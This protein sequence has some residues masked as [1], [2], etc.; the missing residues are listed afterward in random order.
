MD[1]VGM[2]AAG[3]FVLKANIQ[4]IQWPVKVMTTSTCAA[5]AAVDVSQMSQQ[6]KHV[7]VKNTPKLW[8]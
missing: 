3:P 4:G 2:L 8:K 7:A 1:H 6:W 5:K